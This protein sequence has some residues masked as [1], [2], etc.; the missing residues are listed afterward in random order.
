M[1]IPYAQGGVYLRDTTVPVPSK[2][3]VFAVKMVIVVFGH[4]STSLNDY[5]HMPRFLSHKRTRAI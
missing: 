4:L 1:D 2:T 5:Q 3:K